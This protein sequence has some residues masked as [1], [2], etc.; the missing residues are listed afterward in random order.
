MLERHPNVI[1][2]SGESHLYKLLYDPF[3]YLKMMPLQ[4]R[5]K[6]RSW[7]LKHYGPMPI[8]TGFDSN[9]LWQGL[10]RTYRFYEQSGQGSGPHK[11]VDYETFKTLIEKARVSQGD[12][13]KKITQLIVSILDS[14]FYKQ[15][16]DS[17]QTMLEKTPMHIK[18]ASAILHT[19]PEAK[20]V[21]VV[22]DI[23]G[24][25]A[26]WQARAKQQSWARKSIP[27]LVAQWIPM[28]RLRRSRAKRYCHQR[29]HHPC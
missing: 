29:S 23:R 2:L 11:V 10:L 21:E 26:S 27:D 24:V 15:G 4:V 28:R 14:A 5:L 19:F 22:R 17:S 1:K 9:N 3:T 6:Q 12:D 20:M 16:G 8:L 7:I 18:F 13:L 25:C